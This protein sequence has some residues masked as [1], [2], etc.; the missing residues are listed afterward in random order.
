VKTVVQTFELEKMEADAKKAAAELKADTQLQVQTLI[1]EASY[2][3][4]KNNAQKF[5]ILS[6]AEG[7]IAPWLEKKNQFATKEKEM[8]VYNSLAENKDLVISGSS[9]S[10]INLISIADAILHANNHAKGNSRSALIAELALMNKGTA[11]Y[12]GNNE[13]KTKL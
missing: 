12:M 8:S 1:S 5:Q 9:N 11:P 3:A 7:K 10:D 4:A 2:T 6:E 13:E